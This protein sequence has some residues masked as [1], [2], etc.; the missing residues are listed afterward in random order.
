MKQSKK[1]SI[2]TEIKNGYICV[3]DNSAGTNYISV[4]NAAEDVSKDVVSEFGNLPI[5]YKDT[6]GQVDQ[7]IHDD[8]YFLRFEFLESVDFEEA[9]N[10]IEELKLN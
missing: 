8:G 1:Y 4:S 5:L 7:L 2:S 6:T 3:T 10:M 9:I